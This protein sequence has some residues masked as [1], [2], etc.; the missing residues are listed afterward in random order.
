M[1]ATFL[2]LLVLAVGKAAALP[3]GIIY[4]PTVQPPVPQI[5]AVEPIPN[6]EHCEYGAQLTTA[7][8]AEDQCSQI[9]AVLSNQ[10]GDRLSNWQCTYHPAKLQYIFGFIYAPTVTK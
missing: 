9:H 3:T 2:L 5:A 1:K 8:L 4:C 10:F 7:V 6:A